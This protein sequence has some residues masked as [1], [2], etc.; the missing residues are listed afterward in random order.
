MAPGRRPPL[1][2]A[3]GGLNPDEDPARG[4][5]ELADPD[6]IVSGNVWHA[7]ESPVFGRTEK[8]LTDLVLR[9]EDRLI[10]DFWHPGNQFPNQL[11]YYGFAGALQCGREVLGGIAS[12]DRSRG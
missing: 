3:Q 10:G 2:P 8:Q 9:W 6:I 7:V 1:S 4:Q 5:I 11:N 12:L